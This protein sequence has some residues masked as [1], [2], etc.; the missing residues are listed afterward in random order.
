MFCFLIFYVLSL[1]FF[2]LKFY[3]TFTISFRSEKNRSNVKTNVNELSWSETRLISMSS[4][5]VMALALKTKMGNKYNT[6]RQNIQ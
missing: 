1:Y 2:F 5:I 4:G 6:N 3:I